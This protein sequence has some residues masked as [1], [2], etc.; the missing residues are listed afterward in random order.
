MRQI[1]IAV[2]VGEVS[3]VYH[4]LYCCF[5]EHIPSPFQVFYQ[6]TDVR[7]FLH[8][9]FKHCHLLHVPANKEVEEQ[10]PVLWGGLVTLPVTSTAHTNG[11]ELL[12]SV[13]S[14]SACLS[15][16]CDTKQNN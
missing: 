16:V 12:C 14:G 13:W 6:Q 8:D 15:P 9:C 2:C 7:S 10:L 11:R 5:R 4:V 1:K 3:S